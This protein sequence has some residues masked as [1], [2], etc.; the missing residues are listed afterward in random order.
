MCTKMLVSVMFLLAVSM[1]ATA[2]WTPIEDFESGSFGSDWT[3][4][5]ATIS[6]DLVTGTSNRVLMMT[7]GTLQ[8][9]INSHSAL[10]IA[11]NA[12]KTIYLRIATGTGS[13]Y[14]R[15]NWG[16]TNVESPAAE[17]DIKTQSRFNWGTSIYAWDGTTVK[18]AFDLAADG[19]DRGHWLE[20]W[21]VIDNT[22]DQFNLYLQGGT[23]YTTQ[24]QISYSGDSDFAFR[25]AVAD[26]LT[27]L[28]LINNTSSTQPQGYMLVDDIYVSDGVN[29]TSAVPEPATLLL[30]GM[31]S[32]ALL[33]RK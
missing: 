9:A 33:R 13:D 2:A 1:T 11:D 8:T 26:S 21:M 19:A 25:N 18:T 22:A 23:L 12:T 3:V 29:L 16:M 32:L 31:G 14:S 6:T 17:A 15:L 27:R 4:S 10:T 28:F 7:Q 24:T 30:L 5:G 20:M